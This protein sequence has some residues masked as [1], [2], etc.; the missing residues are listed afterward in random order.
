MVLVILIGGLLFSQSYFK[1]NKVFKG[2]AETAAALNANVKPELLKGER[3]RINV[4]LL[5]RGW[6]ARCTRSD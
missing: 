3:G 4:L 6:Y 1:L 2:G 5:G